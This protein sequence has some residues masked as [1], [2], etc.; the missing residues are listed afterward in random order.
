MLNM[1]M[2]EKCLEEKTE[3]ALTIRRTGIILR[4]VSVENI[5]SCVDIYDVLLNDTTYVMVFVN[6]YCI[7]MHTK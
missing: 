3:E 7:H 1:I 6:G 5:H 2:S 4:D